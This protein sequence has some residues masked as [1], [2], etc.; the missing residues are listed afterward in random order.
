MVLIIVYISVFAA[1][2]IGLLV[3]MLRIK[4]AKKVKKNEKHKK[5]G[6]FVSKDANEDGENNKTG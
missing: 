6:T 3:I 2:F 4:P 5:S 1:I